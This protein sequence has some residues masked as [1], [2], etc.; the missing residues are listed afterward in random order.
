MININLLPW[1]EQARGKTKK[2]FLRTLMFSIIGVVILFVLVHVFLARQINNQEQR[3]QYLQQQGDVYNKNIQQIQQLRKLQ[4]EL[5]NRLKVIQEIQDQRPFAVHLFEAFSNTIPNG[6]Y[7]TKITRTNKQIIINGRADA[8]S[9]VSQ[10]MRN[11]KTSKWVNSPS[12]NLIKANKDQT[13][14]KRDFDLR[15]QEAK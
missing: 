6:V 10:L 5:D 11:I 15:M 7:Y 1:R 3:N 12:L 14:Y 9:Q 13:S 8:N 4:K 2:Y